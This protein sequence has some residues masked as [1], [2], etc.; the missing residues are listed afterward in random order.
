MIMAWQHDYVL[1]LRE[2]NH[3]TKIIRT[4][5]EMFQES[6]RLFCVSNVQGDILLLSQGLFTIAGVFWRS[7]SFLDSYSFPWV[8][9]WKDEHLGAGKSDSK[10]SKC[11]PYT[12]PLYL[13]VW[14]PLTAG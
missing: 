9:R 10:E 14:L 6:D 11:S 13:W 7:E 5:P 3:V 2:K 8:S 4:M 12:V 1:F